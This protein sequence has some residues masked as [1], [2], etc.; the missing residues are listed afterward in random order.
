MFLLYAGFSLKVGN[1][2]KRDAIY[3]Y[4]RY[5]QGKDL[6]DA[7]DT[8]MAKIKSLQA[9]GLAGA[10]FTQATDI[11][12]ELNGLITYDRKVQKLY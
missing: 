11:E 2:V 7:F 1:H 4:K 12:D 9:E 5:S 10:V 6:Q 3:G 8:I